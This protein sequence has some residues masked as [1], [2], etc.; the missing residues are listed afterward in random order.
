[1]VADGKGGGGRRGV[2]WHSPSTV[3]ADAAVPVS[4]AS[5]EVHGVTTVRAHD[6]CLW[7]REGP[8]SW[9]HLPELREGPVQEDGQH[10]QHPP[11]LQF[12]R[13][14]VCR[15]GGVSSSVSLSPSALCSRCRC[16]NS[17]GYNLVGVNV[18]AA[19]CLRCGGTVRERVVLLQR[20]ELAVGPGVQSLCRCP[21]DP[22][23]RAARCCCSQHRIFI[24]VFSVVV[25]ATRCGRVAHQTPA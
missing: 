15:V 8:S 25:P 1:M 12:W 22:A 13:W 9:V 4:T 20:P 6:M 5:V 2:S 21:A 11:P 19:C 23:T 14:V 3:F 24:L 7:F 17:W 18:T 10:L 16:P